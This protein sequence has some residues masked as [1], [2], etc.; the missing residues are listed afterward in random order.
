[1]TDIA[2][3]PEIPLS[4]DHLH[5]VMLDAVSD[6]VY[7]VDLN[8]RILFWN[9]AAEEMTGR[10]A[11]DVLGA[12]CSQGALQHVDETGHCLC[13]NG[14]PLLES[15]RS[16]TSQETHLYLLHKEGHRIRVRVRVRPLYDEF[17]NLIGSVE[18][19]RDDSEHQMLLERI[20]AL[21]KESMIDS[22]TGLAN[23]RYFDWAIN[24]CL[25]KHERFGMT[26]GV[27]LLD[28][29]HFKKFND[30]YGHATGDDVLRVVGR[31]LAN[32][33]RAS[34]TPVR[35]G[36]EEFAVLCEQANPEALRGAAERL[37]MLIDRSEV[38]HPDGG[39]SVTVSVGGCIVQKGDDMQSLMQRADKMLYA[40]KQAGR[41]CIR[42]C[43][44]EGRGSV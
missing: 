35:W 3:V 16:E 29:D 17:G 27:L 11:G 7:I 22:L 33:C 20:Q 44:T 19:F 24:S 41:D 36:G 14:C 9:K 13:E 8:R 31:T 12:V 30:T 23:R 5:N 37:H 32:N 34:D 38:E 10:I 2:A 43:S 21:E 25:A 6:G 15:M 26:F 40:A 18:V 1:M 4:I 39:L 42:M 28:V